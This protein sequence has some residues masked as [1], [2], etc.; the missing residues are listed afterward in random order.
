[1][2]S[3]WRYSQ[4]TTQSTTD[5]GQGTPILTTGSKPRFIFQLACYSGTNTAATS[6]SWVVIPASTL[7]INAQGQMNITGDMSFNLGFAP[8]DISAATE[9]QP[10]V[11][12]PIGAKGASVSHIVIPPD[13]FLCA[14]PDINQ[15]GTA[16]HTVISAELDA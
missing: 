7:P 16:I 3:N 5:A 1:M 10:Y 15:N 9:V 11:G 2:Y 8:A 6:I 12:V 14:V 4:T 13:C